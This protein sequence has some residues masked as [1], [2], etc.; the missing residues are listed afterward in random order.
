MGSLK[1]RIA[2]TVAV[3]FGWLIFV[4]SFLAFYPT[5]FDFWQNL[6]FFLVSGL[7]AFGII[8]IIWLSMIWKEL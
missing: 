7:I 8:A 1:T 5:G 2:S 6:A 4:I 3:L